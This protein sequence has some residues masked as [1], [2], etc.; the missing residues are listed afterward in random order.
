[1][2]GVSRP[3][4]FL[5]RDGTLNVKPPEHQYLTSADAFAWLPG[6]Q[7]GAARLAR[8]G[9]V[10]VVASNQRGVARGLVEPAVLSTI[11]GLIQRGLERYECGV[12]AFRYCPHEESAGCD[13]RK[14]R[15]G[16]L[17]DLARDLDLDLARS[18]MI[19]DSDS[20]VLAGQAAGCR[21]VLIGGRPSTCVPDLTAPSLDAASA[22][23]VGSQ[24]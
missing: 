19:G 16:L 5:D 13:C 7:R 24:A 4:V 9:Y 15:P 12:A 22:L 3:A 6:A 18:W 1:M 8:G 23:I 10:L 17:L 20:D 2:D 11:E 14:P 21:T